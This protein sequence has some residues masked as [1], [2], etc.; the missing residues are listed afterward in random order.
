METI[1]FTSEVQWADTIF[2]FS[3]AKID[4]R[5]DA[6]T[7]QISF[8]ESNETAWELLGGMTYFSSWK[9]PI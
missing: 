9:K 3:K 4:F 8:W 2:R 1:Q 5:A 7:L 6:A